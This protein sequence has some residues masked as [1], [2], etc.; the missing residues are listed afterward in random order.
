MLILDSGVHVYRTA[1]FLEKVWVLMF[2]YII[3]QKNIM[4]FELRGAAL[5]V[6]GIRIRFGMFG[7]TR[8]IKTEDIILGVPLNE[9]LETLVGRFQGIY[10]YTFPQ[11]WQGKT[12]P[13]NKT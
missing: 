9:L 1:A 10:G 12:S 13:E 6:R 7:T 5:N 2:N 4:D 3:N 11:S 8:W